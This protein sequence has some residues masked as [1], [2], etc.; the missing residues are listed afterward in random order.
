MEKKEYTTISKPRKG[1]SEAV[2]SNSS[3]I[4]IDSISTGALHVSGI[5]KANYDMEQDIYN[6][7][8]R[9]G[10]KEGRDVGLIQGVAYMTAELMRYRGMDDAVRD[11]WRAWGST[12]QE[13]RENDASEYDLEILT[14]YEQYLD[15]K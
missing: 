6:E 9:Q 15:G 13:A 1:K 10:Y 4:V 7:G 8:K 2:I 14:K 5:P 12:V 3:D 11:A